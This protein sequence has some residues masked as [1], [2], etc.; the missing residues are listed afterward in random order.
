MSTEEN[1][2]NNNFS[3]LIKVKQGVDNIEELRMRELFLS[4]SN[5]K[6]LSPDQFF[7]PI[8]N[9]NSN[10]NQQNK[11]SII[12]EHQKDLIP[13]KSQIR[14]SIHYKDNDI[15]RNSFIFNKTEDMDNMNLTN[16]SIDKS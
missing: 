8:N 11:S 15:R 1:I 14:Q 5:E 9:S 6:I 10:I 7:S 3:N 12:R 16:R 4:P 13:P 2:A